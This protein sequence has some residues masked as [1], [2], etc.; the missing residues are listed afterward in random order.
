MPANIPENAEILVVVHGTPLKDQTEEWNA[1][2]YASNWLDFAEAN[3]LAL[4]VPLS[5]QQ[6]FSSRLGDHALG[7]YRN[8]FV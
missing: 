4:I 5:N 6:D 2:Y 7:G 3:N 8:N 1:E